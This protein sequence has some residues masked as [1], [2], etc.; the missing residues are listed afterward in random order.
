MLRDTRVSTTTGSCGALA[1]GG[2]VIDSNLADPSLSGMGFYRR[3][4]L[5]VAGMELRVGTFN[6]AS[7]AILTSQIC[8]TLIG[9]G[10]SYEIHDLLPPSDKDRCTDWTMRRIRYKQEVAIATVDGAAVYTIDG[11]ASPNLITDVLDAYVFADPTNSLDRAQ[12]GLNEFRLV[13]TASGSNELR[14][15]PRSTQS[16]QLVMLAV[17]APSL[18]SGDAATINV[19]DDRWILEGMASRAFDLLIQRSPSQEAQLFKERR[20]EHARN[21]TALSSDYQPDMARQTELDAPW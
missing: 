1:S 20:L 6:A 8:A 2:Y 15:S 4:W 13:Q 16:Q 21:F 14:V 10:V 3:A 7:G 9:S 19:P 5:K 17:L 18:P 11:A 12:H